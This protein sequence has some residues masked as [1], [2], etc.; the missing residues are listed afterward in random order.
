MKKIIEK[1]DFLQYEDDNDIVIA[2][3]KGW[4]I[5]IFEKDT[6]NNYIKG[7]YSDKEEMISAFM[8][9]IGESTE[10][11][12][13]FT[14]NDDEEENDLKNEETLKELEEFFRTSG[15]KIDINGWNLQI[16]HPGLF[17]WVSDNSED[18]IY[19]NPLKD[20]IIFRVYDKNE[21][22]IKELTEDISFKYDQDIP[23]KTNANMYLKIIS[24]KIKKIEDELKNGD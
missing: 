18:I 10:V 2:K 16:V 4:E 9:E 6:K 24:E 5:V 19:A 20:T 3:P 8:E 13:D 11:E 17:M 12:Y 1:P 14:D 21:E 22:E 7:T 15:F 23:I